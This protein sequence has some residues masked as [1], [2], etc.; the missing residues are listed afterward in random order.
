MAVKEFKKGTE[1]FHQGDF[2]NAMYELIDGKAG[3]YVRYTDGEEKKLTD[4][5]AGAMFGEMALI[6][7]YARSATVIAEEDLVADEINAEEAEAY[8]RDDPEKVKRILAHLSHRLR[9]LTEDFNDVCGSIYKVEQTSG[10]AAARGEGFLSKIQK[11][12]KIAKTAEPDD[13]ESAEQTRIHSDAKMNGEKVTVSQIY[14]KGEVI[15]REGEIGDC[16]YFLSIGLVRILANY[17]KPEEKK[18]TDIMGGS[19]FG[20]MGL[21]EKL[22]R[23]ATAV[24]MTDETEVDIIYEKDLDAIIER[25]PYQT[26][27]LLQH[28]SMR[29]RTLTEDY[30]KA[31]K[32]L[33]AMIVAEDEK[34]ELD[35]DY[36]GLQAL[37]SAQ[38]KALNR[39]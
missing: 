15:F 32:T 35:S 10:N 13:K 1:I 12:L 27:M 22:P 21:I 30:I 34:R 24:S 31:C 18:I 8:F 11:F 9:E 37:Y 6:D 38:A 23:S 33:H 7:T 28:L 29:L 20:E 26:K 17:G 25:N 4:L 3:V 5:T 14:K 19:L 16:M 2:G 36:K 39:W